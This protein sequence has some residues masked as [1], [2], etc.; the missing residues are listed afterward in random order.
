MTALDH[1]NEVIQA[2]AASAAQDW[3]GDATIT[4]S[5]EV[6]I[7]KQLP[8]LD[9]LPVGTRQFAHECVQVALAKI[10]MLFEKTGKLLK[11]ADGVELTFGRDEVV[12]WS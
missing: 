4:R 2:A 12:W 6:D 3:N 5:D 11:V 8:Q 7:G 9:V 10:W 1:S